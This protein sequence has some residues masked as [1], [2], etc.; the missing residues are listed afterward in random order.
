MKRTLSNAPE[1]L[2]AFNGAAVGGL[3]VLGGADDGEGH[4]VDEGLRVLG[5]LCVVD[6]DGGAVDA[7]ALGL[8]DG[9]DA[10]LEGVEVVAGEGVGLGDD[11]DEVDAGAEALHDLN[12]ER[13]E[14]VAGGP[15]EVQAGV[16]PQVRL[17]RPVRLLLLPHVHLVLVVDEV[18]D[19]RPRVAVVDVVAET[20]RVD[21]RQLHLE[22]LFLQLGLDNLNLRRGVSV[23]LT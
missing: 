8:D 5:A 3:D 10:L 18:D 16:H 13:L 21:D 1:V 22:R 14:V 9:A 11:G 19:G 7:D 2:A 6:L 4:G 12:V 23:E 15:D 17:V 20:G